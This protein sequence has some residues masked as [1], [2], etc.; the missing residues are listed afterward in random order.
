MAI[1]SA[2]L[3]AITD[4]IGDPAE[5]D[6]TVRLRTQFPPLTFAV[7]ADDDVIGARPV[8]A[9]VGFRLY[10]IDG[11]DHCLRLTSDPALASGVLV[12]WSDTAD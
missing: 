2:R 5:P 10:L 11:S 3:A 1:D 12:T 8:A 9:G 4:A 7:C 6:L